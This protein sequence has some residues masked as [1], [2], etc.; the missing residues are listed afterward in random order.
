MSVVSSKNASLL[1]EKR[2]RMIWDISREGKH[3]YL[4]GTAHFF[5]YS[6]RKSLKHYIHEVDTV[7]IEGPLDED[8]MNKVVE[9]GSYCDEAHLLRDSL[10]TEAIEK[11]AQELT[12]PFKC[13]ST[14]FQ[15]YGHVMEKDTCESLSS[16][17]S[18]MKPWLA[19]FSI[20][21]QYLR[22]RGWGYS[23]DKDA[24]LIAN[25]MGRKVSYL[26]S[27][28]EQV[29]AL[30]HIPVERIVAFLRKIDYW[31]EYTNRYV[32]VFLKGDLETLMT[33]AEIFPTRCEAVIENRDVVLYERLMTHID[34][35]RCLICVGSTH[36]RGMSKMLQNDGWSV[37]QRWKRKQ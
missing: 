23:M 4:V 2:L 30:E 25:E 9:L 18:G 19:F 32:K 17:L 13:R 7:L 3:S 21:Y 24:Y 26:E 29:T 12:A 22:M 1:K 8:T 15:F 27:I 28:D 11:I 20:W 34:K 36:I 33:N 10:G 14:F 31:K 6:F 35:E 16:T 37:Q 5:P